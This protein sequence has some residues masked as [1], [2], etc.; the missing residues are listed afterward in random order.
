MEIVHRKSKT[1]IR[2]LG[3]KYQGLAK[4]SARI[5]GEI[6]HQN[7]GES[8]HVIKNGKIYSLAPM[9]A[10]AQFAGIRVKPTVSDLEKFIRKIDEVV[11]DVDTETID[12]QS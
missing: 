10:A 9:K 12:T 5:F 7:A 4:E 11:P 8:G 1:Y 3:D 2:A 6:N